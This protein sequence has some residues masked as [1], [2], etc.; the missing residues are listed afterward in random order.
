MEHKKSYVYTGVFDKNNV[1]LKVGDM[2]QTSSGRVIIEPFGSHIAGS[3]SYRPVGATNPTSSYSLQD[4]LKHDNI[5]LIEC[6]KP[7]CYTFDAKTF[8]TRLHETG[9][10]FFQFY[11]LEKH[12]HTLSP[13]TQAEIHEL[14]YKI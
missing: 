14:L 8:E 12:W 11:Q 6:K 5:E 7:N 4:L 13:T 9:I 3:F 10:L 2:V 1:E